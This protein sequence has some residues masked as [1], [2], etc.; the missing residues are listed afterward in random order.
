MDVDELRSWI[1]AGAGAAPLSLQMFST[2][3]ILDQGLLRADGEDARSLLTQQE[4]LTGVQLVTEVF[5]KRSY[6]VVADGADAV[7]GLRHRVVWCSRKSPA[8]LAGSFARQPRSEA[9]SRS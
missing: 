9:R 1:L 6:C 7:T 4:P 3:L 8:L 2:D 5:G